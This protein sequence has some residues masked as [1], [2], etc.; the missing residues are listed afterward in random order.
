MPST[1][2]LD[3]AR[4]GQMTPSAQWALQDFVRVAGEEGCTLYFERFFQDGFSAWPAS[5]QKQ[6]AGLRSW[7]GVAELKAALATFAGLPTD[8][9]P[10]L[11]G[12]STNLMKL[13]ANVLFRGGKRVLVTD[14]TWPSYEKILKREAR[15]ANGRI[16]S[17]RIRA[18]I[19]RGE[20]SG[21]NLIDRM[22]K[23]IVATKCDGVFLPAISH[24]GIRLPI[25]EIVQAIREFSPSS[26]IVVDGSQAFGQMPVN[27][28]LAP[29]DFFLA[30]C[31]KWLGSHLPLGIAFCPNP[32]THSEIP[33]RCADRLEAR[34]LDD[35]LLAF[36]TSIETGRMRRFTETVNLSPLFSCRGALEDQFI[37]GPIAGRFRR[38]IANA[39]L[40]Q[41]IARMTGW[42]PLL[43]DREFQSASVLLQAT[44]ATVREWTPSHLRDRFHARGIALTC[45]DRGVIRLSMPSVPLSTP[46]AGLLIQALAMVHSRHASQPGVPEGQVL[47]A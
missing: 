38:R 35:P 5:Y 25:E 22:L 14:L 27:L 9:R 28:S 33:Q 46:E 21:T 30:G 34:K 32:A 39:G 19:V 3:A 29:C 42:I 11:A 47:S 6:F 12:R 41:R 8:S 23:R 40:V 10:L 31:H 44:S 15:M 16:Q 45:Y 2:Y 20:I 37:E 36:L 13:A 26:F 1:L 4:M 18:A 17:L 24:D 7:G 43:P